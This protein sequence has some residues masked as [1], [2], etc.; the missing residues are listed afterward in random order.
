M[1]GNESHQISVITYKLIF[2]S[3]NNNREGITDWKLYMYRD[4]IMRLK[5]FISIINLPLIQS[6]GTPIKDIIQ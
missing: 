2:K 3:A 4:K 1:D 6:T 5:S